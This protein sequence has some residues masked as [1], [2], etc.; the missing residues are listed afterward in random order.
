MPITTRNSRKTSQ[1]APKMRLM[2]WLSL[3]VKRNRNSLS[4][5][6]SSSTQTIT[7]AM[8][9]SRMDRLFISLRIA[10]T[11]II[12]MSRVSTQATSFRQREAT[13]AIKEMELGNIS[14]QM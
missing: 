5:S 7:T 2:P 3:R 13:K 11:T 6:S 8:E 4:S 14:L 10:T 1:I 9:P 12:G